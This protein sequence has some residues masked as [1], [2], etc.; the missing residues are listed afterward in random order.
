MPGHQE[1]M[2]PPIVDTSIP[3]FA[4]KPDP[5]DNIAR[6]NF[7]LST[8]QE[9]SYNQMCYYAGR[10]GEPNEVDQE[11][12]TPCQT[13]YSM[14][15]VLTDQTTNK[16]V[17]SLSDFPQEISNHNIGY[18][19]SDTHSINYNLFQCSIMDE[20]L[21]GETI[22]NVHHGWKSGQYYK[23]QMRLIKDPFIWNGVNYAYDGCGENNSDRMNNVIKNDNSGMVIKRSSQENSDTYRGQSA[24]FYY[25]VEHYLSQSYQTAYNGAN[26]KAQAQIDA[27]KIGTK[28]EYFNP[29]T[30]LRAAMSKRREMLEWLEENGYCSEWSTICLI[31]AIEM[32]EWY[33]NGEYYSL[34]KDEQTH[35]LEPIDYNT[36]LV[37]ISGKVIIP[38]D[39]LEP[40]TLRD[41]RFTLKDDMGVLVED[42]G[43]M[44][45][46][47]QDA[48][49]N[50]YYKFKHILQQPE[51][52]PEEEP[53]E[54]VEE[55]D[56][57][58]EYSLTVKTT[59]RNGWNGGFTT[60]LHIHG[61][62][63]RIKKIHLD[64]EENNRC[65]Y[66][67]MIITTDNDFDP[68]YGYDGDAHR[69][70]YLDYAI[71]RTDSTSGFTTAEE[72]AIVSFQGQRPADYRG[73]TF[74]IMDVTAESGIQYQYGIQT[75]ESDTQR[76][77]ELQWIT[78]QT[79]HGERNV[80]YYPFYEDMFL[81]NS[82]SHLA[83]SFGQSVSDYKQNVK[84]ARIETIGAQFP[85]IYRNQI[86]NYRTLTLTGT[87]SYNDNNEM[88]IFSWDTVYNDGHNYQSNNMVE[89]PFNKG[90]R[91]RNDLFT[92][93]Q[94]RNNYDDFNTAYNIDN[95]NDI[96][97]EREYRK[98][99]I[100]F[101]Q[102]GKPMLLKTS[103]EGN[104]LVMIMDVILAPKTSLGN[105]VYDFTCTAVEIA[106]CSVENYNKYNVQYLEPLKGND[107]QQY[108]YHVSVLKVG[109]I[110]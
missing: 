65:G 73:K 82:D 23:L 13:L 60:M 29:V 15:C 42:S 74:H 66:V 68:I 62:G 71:I 95:Y 33:I 35:Q 58:V 6:I 19:N 1:T 78:E 34:E 98:E 48:S 5:T 27:G 31:R 20:E 94:V 107:Q 44:L 110:I 93:E 88:N 100:K 18:R 81:S 75:I 106:D 54:E 53:Q 51:L 26:T 85:Y 14:Q 25:M 12:P 59:S 108:D 83:I 21:Q 28:D 67:E 7:D 8:F 86:V 70:L 91:T 101:L 38:E 9:N 41:I 46:N 24:D 39:S 84:E 102:S 99:V 72:I 92:S 77:G 76:R 69:D 17:L 49:N 109:Q 47:A 10:K 40:E 80:T 30:V 4:L 36:P 97:L 56:R 52:D 90:F 55:E 57:Y 43:V 22:D 87:I 16:T 105:I 96:T 11:S 37:A 61:S 89:V 104:I 2:Y 50:F 3:I 64:C 63:Q 45:L 103:A 79:S 32:P